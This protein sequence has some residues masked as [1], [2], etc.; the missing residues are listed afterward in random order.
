MKLD[1]ENRKAIEGIEKAKRIL[2]EIEELN[3]SA[4][5]LYDKEK[6]REALDTWQKVLNL[7]S[8]NKTAKGGIKKAEK[9]SRG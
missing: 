1:S 5:Q 8:E 6:Y 9:N 7:D 3:T 4:Q 2:K